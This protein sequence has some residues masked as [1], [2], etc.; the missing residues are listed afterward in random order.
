MTKNKKETS[1]FS[2][3][4]VYALLVY[5]VISILVFGIAFFNNDAI[6]IHNNYKC[7]YHILASLLLLFTL[8]NIIFIIFKKLFA[9]GVIL[10]IL[11]SLSVV[12]FIEKTIVFF[13]LNSLTFGYYACY[14]SITCFHLLFFIYRFFKVKE[15]LDFMHANKKIIIEHN[16]KITK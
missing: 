2:F 13:F 7:I 16:R 6:P 5:I 12:I 10:N 8:I 15:I 11:L 1:I 9:E 14:I 4:R 3:D